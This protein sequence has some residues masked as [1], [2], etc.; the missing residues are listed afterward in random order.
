VILL[1]RLF[2][3]ISISEAMEEEYSSYIRGVVIPSDMMTKKPM[4]H[5]FIHFLTKES[6]VC[7]K[8]KLEKFTIEG[9]P[10]Q[11]EWA[12]PRDG[13]ENFRDKKR[14][15]LK[16]RDTMGDQNRRPRREGKLNKYELEN[17][18]F[19]GCLP[20][21]GPSGPPCGCSCMC[22]CNGGSMDDPYMGIKLS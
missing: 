21:L 10:I 9:K 6:A 18:C 15:L 5:A 4:G 13:K 11:V 22:K 12:L 17:Q 8:K 16:L 14:E 19:C 20:C 2:T 7:A 3:F 1:Y